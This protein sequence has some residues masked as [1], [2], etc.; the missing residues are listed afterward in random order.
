MFSS[1]DLLGMRSTQD[2]HM[3]DS[4]K[5]QACVETSD[6]FGELVQ[7]WPVDGSELACGLDQGPG[8]ERHGVDKVILEYDATIRLPIAT[9]PGAKDRIK[10]TKRFGEASEIIYE[11]VGPIQRGASGIRLLLKKVET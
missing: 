5:I 11:I 6:P 3:M 8:I 4:C 9:A 7:T 10:V 2:S 1:A